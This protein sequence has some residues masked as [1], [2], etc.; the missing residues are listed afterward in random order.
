MVTRNSQ[1][2]MEPYCHGKDTEEFFNLTQ[3]F[4]GAMKEDRSLINNYEATMITK[5]RQEQDVD[6]I[7]ILLM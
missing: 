5:V 2:N 4:F 6:Y 3:E 7:L 1:S